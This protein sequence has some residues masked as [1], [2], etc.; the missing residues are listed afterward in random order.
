MDPEST[1]RA[2][3]FI[4][5]LAMSVLVGLFTYLFAAHCFLT[6]VQQTAAGN[7][8]IRWPNE[9]LY[10]KLPRAGYLACLLGIW[11]APAGLLLRL[12]RDSSIGDSSLLTFLVSAAILIWGV[13]PIGLFSALSGSSPWMIFRVRV[14]QLFLRRFGA[15][16]FFYLVSAILIAGSFGLLYLAFATGSIIFTFT[17]PPVIAAA[18]MIHARLLGRMAYLFDQLPVR[19]FRNKSSARAE[20]GLAAKSKKKKQTKAVEDPWALPEELPKPKKVKRK[21]DAIEGY[22]IADNDEA[23][24]ITKAKPARRVNAYRLADEPP[25]N[26][27]LEMPADGYIPVGYEAIKASGSSP[28]VAGAMGSDFD[29][30]FREKPA[31]EDP[32]PANPLISGVFSF[33]W[34]PGNIPAWLLLTFGGVALCGLI[35]LMLHFKPPTGE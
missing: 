20:Q 27:P 22:A 24:P 29:Q 1:A 25:T 13:F 32:P 11:I 19:S 8:G 9:P 30:R 21:V 2:M 23:P 7:D 35:Q 12:N 17:A 26:P 14:L 34:Y 15:T 6:I 33:P 16:A 5:L 4:S 28:S 31:D 3:I 18:F 10:D